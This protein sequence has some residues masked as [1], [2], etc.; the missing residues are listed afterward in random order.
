MDTEKKYTEE[1]IKA[2]ANEEIRKA[3]LK[4]NRELNLDEMENVAGG[5]NLKD[6]TPITDE[7]IDFYANVFK[8]SGLHAD[9]LFTSAENFGFPFVKP[10]AIEDAERNGV[11][12]ADAWSSIMKRI[13]NEGGFISQ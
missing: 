10:K 2:I 6:G 9:A 8:G 4:A 5:R 1:E 12:P 3:G 13:I 11:N 7:V